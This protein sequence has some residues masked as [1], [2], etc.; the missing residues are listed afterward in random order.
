MRKEIEDIVN[1]HREEGDRI[2]D[3]EAESVIRHCNRKM[4]ASRIK[5]KEAYLPALFEDELN[6]FI[7]RRAVNAISILRGMEKEAGRNVRVM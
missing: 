4:D 2:S 7:A 5:N 6:H 1:R 3:E